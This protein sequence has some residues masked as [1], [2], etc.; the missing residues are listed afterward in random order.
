MFAFVFPSNP[1][2]SKKPD[3]DY[4]AEYEAI[5]AKGWSVYLIDVDALDNLKKAQCWPALNP[6][7]VLIYR[8]WM[9]G[10]EKYALLDDALNGQL[11]VKTQNYLNSHHLPNWIGQVEDISPQTRVTSE[12]NAAYLFN[13]LGWGRA[14]IK[15]YVK[16]L[17][18]GKG[19][20]VETSEDVIRAIHDMKQYRGSIEGGIVLREV[21][22]LKPN[23]EVR[24][25]VLNQ[26]L[27]CPLEGISDKI[28]ADIWDSMKRVALTAMHQH[29]EFFY[30][31]DV[32]LDTKDKPY[33]IEIGD[34]QVSGLTGWSVNNFANIMEN[35]RADSSLHQKVKP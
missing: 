19:S 9:L 1:L 20:I 28:E 5:K 8:G 27:Y 2:N 35:L 21:L 15:D 25:F 33:L 23:S 16:S 10:L 18:T 34:A 31:I 30:T 11:R 7:E 32:A 24:F 12:I 13:D 29:P 26:K 17:K 4:K 3:D 14:F 22:D 6:D